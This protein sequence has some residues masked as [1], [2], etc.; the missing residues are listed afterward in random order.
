M[1]VREVKGNLKVFGITKRYGKFTRKQKCPATFQVV[2]AVLL[3]I[4]ISWHFRIP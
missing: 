4:K 3:K 2:T 1:K